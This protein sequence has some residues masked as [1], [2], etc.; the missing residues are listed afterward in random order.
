MSC[1]SIFAKLAET[2]PKVSSFVTFATLCEV[3]SFATLCEVSSFT[4]LCEV[5]SSMRENR[6]TVESSIACVVSESS[7]IYFAQP[8]LVWNM[9]ENKVGVIKYNT[10]TASGRW[11]LEEIKI[12]EL[13]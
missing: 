2:I 13:L 5:S 6:V 12:E 7:E 8:L 11:T 1:I 10:L 9:G 3:S 4:T